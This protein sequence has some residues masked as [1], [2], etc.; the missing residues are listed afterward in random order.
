MLLILEL[1][2][3][4]VES[5]VLH[6][7]MNPSNER[8]PKGESTEAAQCTVKDEQSEQEKKLS[9]WAASTVSSVMPEQAHEQTK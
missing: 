2:R 7:V 8:T 6:Q 3:V 9:M 4:Q 1:V 5:V